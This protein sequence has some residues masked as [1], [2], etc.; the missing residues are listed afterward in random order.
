MIALVTW[1][2]SMSVRTHYT[3]PTRTSKGTPVRA[4]MPF[5]IRPVADCVRR[6]SRE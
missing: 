2:R 3:A 5:A 4:M 6:S 1:P